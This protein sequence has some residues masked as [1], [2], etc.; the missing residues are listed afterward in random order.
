MRLQG[1]LQDCHHSKQHA[2]QQQY[3]N[4]V[5]TVHHVSFSHPY[6]PGH[7][8]WACCFVG[9]RGVGL[10]AAATPGRWRGFRWFD[11]ASTC[12]WRRRGGQCPYP[13]R[14]RKGGVP[15][16][17]YGVMSEVLIGYFRNVNR[18]FIWV[19]VLLGY[20]GVFKGCLGVSK[21]CLPDRRRKGGQEIHWY[22]PSPAL[23]PAP[24]SIW[25]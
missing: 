17:W 3:T 4:S 20:L 6:L 18:L 14:R 19:G 15:F 9:R 22:D 10:T 8:S 21:G 2:V 5:P 23:S 7:T 1:R 12:L 16:E 11:S 25:S 13:G 24:S